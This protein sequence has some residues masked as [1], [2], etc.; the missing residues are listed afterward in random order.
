MPGGVPFVDLARQHEAIADGL[1]AA[2]DRVMTLERV[3]PRGGGRA[4]SRPSSPRT[5]ASG[6]AWGWRRA[7]RL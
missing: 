7:R 1:K 5:A 2:F 3:R 6:I 4:V